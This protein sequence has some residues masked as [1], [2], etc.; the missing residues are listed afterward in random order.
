MATGFGLSLAFP[1][2]IGEYVLPEALARLSAVP[3]I[4]PGCRNR[5]Y[6]SAHYSR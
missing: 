3:C 2:H 5:G 1:I 4:L 6:L